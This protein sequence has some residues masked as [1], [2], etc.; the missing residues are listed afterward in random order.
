MPSDALL[1]GEQDSGHK[2]GSNFDGVG[3]ILALGDPRLRPRLERVIAVTNPFDPDLR[4]KVVTG[5]IVARSE[6]I[7][8][9]LKDEH[10]R[11][12]LLQVRGTQLG[13]LPGR[14]EGI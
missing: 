4:G 8:L 7:A 12:H 13:R 9:A 14:M 6:R 1:N 3:Q 10:R 5:Y 11:G 2:C